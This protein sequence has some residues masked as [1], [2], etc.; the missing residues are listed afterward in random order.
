MTAKEIL[1]SP[2]RLLNLSDVII[3]G[4]IAILAFQTMAI[5]GMGYHRWML[6]RGTGSAMSPQ[7]I[8]NPQ[9]NF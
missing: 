3:I 4:L 8:I 6:W 5:F 2:W 9:G 7:S 1:G